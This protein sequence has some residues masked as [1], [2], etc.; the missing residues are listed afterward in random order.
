M[1][2]G[3]PGR[4]GMISQMTLILKPIKLPGLESQTAM[5]ISQHLKSCFLGANSS[6][7]AR[8]KIGNKFTY[9]GK[10]KILQHED[11]FLPKRVE[12]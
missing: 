4:T 10:G 5:Q 7:F 9:L 3:I 11:H 2:I 6:F 8:W 12:L 1:N